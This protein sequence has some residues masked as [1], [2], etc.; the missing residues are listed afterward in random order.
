MKK[1]ALK[2]LKAAHP[3]LP[4]HELNKLYTRSKIR[5]VDTREKRSKLA[6]AKERDELIDKRLAV[7][8]LTFLFVAMR[9][10]MLLAPLGWHRKFLHITDPHVAVE[11]LTE[12]QHSILRELHDMPRKAVDPGWLESLQED[13]A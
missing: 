12:M 2:D 1:P 10:K 8:Q 9:Q 4:Q 13:D 11:R 7:Q 6:L 5:Y 3:E